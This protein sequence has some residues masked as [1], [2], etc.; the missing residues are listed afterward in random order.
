MSS[1][2]I[3]RARKGS[4]YGKACCLFDNE[5]AISIICYWYHH[6]V[7]YIILCIILQGKEGWMGGGGFLCSKMVC[8]YIHVVLIHKVLF[9]KIIITIKSCVKNKKLSHKITL[10]FIF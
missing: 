10:F 2:C 5:P 6:W 3:R 7:S 4:T 9:F 8:L 1:E